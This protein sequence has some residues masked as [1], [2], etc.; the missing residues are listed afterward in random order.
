[1]NRSIETR[2]K[3]LEARLVPE[4]PLRRSH[5]VGGRTAAEADAK[6]AEMLANGAAGPGDFFI[7]L[8]PLKGDPNSVMHNNH[9]WD[10]VAGRWVPKEGR[11][12]TSPAVL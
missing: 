2:L 8:L 12:A 11:D 4:K 3:R 1:M 6:I 7:R 5:I 9:R 10:E